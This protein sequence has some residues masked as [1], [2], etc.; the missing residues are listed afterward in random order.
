MHWLYA[1]LIGD[2]L[3]QND[4]MAMNKKKSDWHCLVHAVTY[5]IPFLWCGMAVWQLFAVAAQHYVVDRY[6]IVPWLMR[7]KGS[8]G[9]A[10][11][12]CFPWSQIVVDN[13]L[14]IL[15]IA[16]VASGF[17]LNIPSVHW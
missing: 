3:I 7:V 1:H 9:F 14:H 15:W 12:P 17:A 10:T 5:M 4:W 13:V 11:G 6:Q 2:Y 8:N 16:W